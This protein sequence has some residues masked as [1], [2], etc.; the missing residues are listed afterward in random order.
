[1]SRAD[2]YRIAVARA[3]AR[4]AAFMASA[5]DARARIAPARLKSDVKEKLVTRIG[6]TAQSMAETVRTRPGATAAVILGVG[7]WFAR[8]PIA[9]LF[10]RLYVRVRHPDARPDIMETDNG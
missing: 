6:N 4:R 1:M 5:A 10:Q 7:A 8:R 9:A 2:H 3:E